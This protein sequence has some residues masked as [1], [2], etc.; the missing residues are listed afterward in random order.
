MKLS[1]FKNPKRIFFIGLSTLIIGVG[2]GFQNC[3]TKHSQD[4]D[5]SEDSK[6]ISLLKGEIVSKEKVQ[7]ETKPICTDEKSCPSEIA[8]QVLPYLSEARD[9]TKITKEKE[10]TIASAIHNPSPLAIGDVYVA[11]KDNHRVQKFDSSGNYLLQWGSAGTG[12]GQFDYPSAV[13]VDSNQNVYVTDRNLSRVQKFDANGVYISQWSTTGTLAITSDTNNELYVPDHNNHLVYKFDSSGNFLIQWGY[14]TWGTGL[15]S[16]TP[17]AIASD[18]NNNVYTLS[19]KNVQKFDSSGNFLLQWG[20]NGGGG[21]L[22][23]SANS[24]GTDYNNNVYVTDYNLKIVQKFDS[25]GNFLLQFGSVGTGNGQFLKT[26][27]VATDANNDVYVTDFDLHRVQKFDSNGNYILQWGSNGSGNGQFNRPVGIATIP[28][29]RGA[30]LVVSAISAATT[31]IP[32]GATTDNPFY[33]LMGFPINPAPPVPVDV[34]IKNIGNSDAVIPANMSISLMI[35][36]PDYSQCG[37]PNFGQ[38]NFNFNGF[39]Y[40]SI[41]TAMVLPP[42]GTHTIQTDSFFPFHPYSP[43]YSGSTTYIGPMWLWAG[44]D[45]VDG[46][47]QNGDLVDESDEINNFQGPVLP[48]TVVP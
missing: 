38:N 29:P 3:G 5:N 13:T 39:K 10:R 8:K 25:N 32:V 47:I 6:S 24:L 35:H 34:T 37:W 23:S 44:V 46:S 43:P 17:N 31:T 16:L 19:Y 22:F 1:H 11:D 45:T 27:G 40:I 33:P 9:R 20:G 12:N 7:E 15:F 4:A 42:G 26:V 14:A 41:G 36:C 48:I 28:G 30:D 2:V 21:G 18:L